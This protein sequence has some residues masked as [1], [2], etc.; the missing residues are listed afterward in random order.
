MDV[1][2]L[3]SVLRLYP[4][5]KMSFEYKSVR[6]NLFPSACFCWHSGLSLREMD[7][8]IKFGGP[9]GFWNSCLDS[10]FRYSKIFRLHV[11]LHDAARAVRT[12]S[13]KGPRYCYMIGR[14]TNSSLLSHVTGILFCLYVE[15][16]LPSIFNSVDFWSE[17]YLIVLDIELTEK[18]VI[19]D[20][21]FFFLVF[22]KDFHFVHQRLWNPINR[23][24]WTQDIYMELRGVVE[25]WIMRGCLLS[26]T[27]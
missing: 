9:I 6:K 3:I 11:L 18:N 21:G 16:F 19:K 8:K 1:L 27:T 17:V 12:H 14:G 26:F 5:L 25:S 15:I 13:G 10:V 22:Y 23:Q 2:F 20:L 4:G 7:Q 24:H